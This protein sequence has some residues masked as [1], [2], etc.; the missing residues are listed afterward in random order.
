MGLSF[1]DLEVS[2]NLYLLT[3]RLR[4]SENTILCYYLKTGLVMKREKI[5]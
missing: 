4:Y 3:L 5:L 2:T 1:F